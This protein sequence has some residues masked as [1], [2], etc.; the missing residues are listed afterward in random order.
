[1]SD[2]PKTTPA[3]SGDARKPGQANDADQPSPERKD[4]LLENDL[5]NTFPASDPVTPKHIT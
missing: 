4:E 1:M 5:E 2:D 3:N